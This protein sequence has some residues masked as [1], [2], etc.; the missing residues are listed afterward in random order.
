MKKTP[1]TRKFSRIQYLECGLTFAAITAGYLILLYMDLENVID[2]SNIL[3]SALRHGKLLSFY[4]YSVEQASSN[5][6]ANY[7][8]PVFALFAIWQAP[9]LFITKLAGKDYLEWPVSLLWSK[10]LL[11]L[12]MVA[13]AYMI[14]K[15]V[16]LCTQNEEKGLLAVF[17]YFSSMIV[18]FPVIHCGQLEVIS[19]L[20]MLV[21]IY[22]YLRENMRLFW[23]GFLLAVPFKGFALLLALPLLLLR[24]KHL[25][26]VFA[27]LASMT[28]LLLIEKILFRGSTVYKYALLSQNRD[29][30]GQMMETAQGPLMILPYVVCYLVLLIWVY[31]RK[32]ANMSE[33]IYMC[34]F[35]W[36]TFMAFSYTRSYWNFLAAP[37]LVMCLSIYDRYLREGILIETIGS[38][39][40]FLKICAESTIEIRYS[41]L[42]NKLLLPC[43]M[44]IP[45]KNL[46]YGNPAVLFE[47]HGWSIY[48]PLFSTV[49]V[50]ALI[51]I[52][53]LAS[54]YM[55]KTKR[56]KSEPDRLIMLLRPILLGLGLVMIIYSYTAVRN[57]V[58]LNTRNATEHVSEYD[59][60]TDEGTTTLCQKIV[61]PKKASPEEPEGITL[62]FSNTHPSRAN[63]AVLKI[64]IADATDG[65]IVAEA[66]I[67]CSN[68]E[69]DVDKTID[70]KGQEMLPGREYEIRLSCK[71]GIEKRKQRSA[72]YPYLVNSEEAGL[73][74][75][76]IGGEKMEGTLYFELR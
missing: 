49:Y 10:L 48:A 11:V 64:E 21:G 39:C 15:I 61:I 70:L 66:E 12:F 72:L 37:F 4:E 73:P 35:M 76:T 54:P 59:L 47:K 5:Y 40:L 13:V 20:F 52:L 50:T 31:S 68:L 75:C 27:A 58:L 6:A 51:A 26:K 16:L 74:E 46:K 65:S 33:V 18:Y 42:I 25:L 14:Y 30:I 57:P 44:H 3:L 17:L 19:M 63:M 28:G 55:Q 53:V 69:N 29:V 71:E 8:F 1:F 62:K 43:I 7:S 60:I 9:M 22:Y 23:A 41:G 67:T 56:E 38:F 32:S 36:S 34:S 45:E 24:E 2:N